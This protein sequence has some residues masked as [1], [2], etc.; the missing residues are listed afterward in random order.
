MYFKTFEPA[1]ELDGHIKRY[2]IAQGEGLL[3]FR[4][5]IPDMSISLCFHIG[6]YAEYKNISRDFAKQNIHKYKEWAQEALNNSIKI[7]SALI[8]PHK[9]IIMESAQNGLHTFCIEFNTGIAKQFFGIPIQKI[10]DKVFDIHILKSVILNELEYIIINNR[11]EDLPKRIN[12]YLISNNKNEVKI[13][14]NNIYATIKAIRNNPFQAK[15]K[16]LAEDNNLCERHFNRL[17]K[18]YTGISPQQFIT[19]AKIQK[20]LNL[21][22]NSDQ[23]TQ[24]ILCKCGYYDLGHLNREFKSFG[25]ITATQVINNLRNR[26]IFS[27]DP[28]AAKIDDNDIWWTCYL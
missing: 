26:R 10:T 20:C 23:S 7:N 18:A 16:N 28:I 13:K 12:Q 1:K 24:D 27:P 5:I 15:V 21:F 6:K 14:S 3:F 11:I 4:E 2:W 19:I 17:F 8:G 25:G 22:N 9:D